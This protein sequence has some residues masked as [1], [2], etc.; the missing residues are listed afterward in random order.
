MNNQVDDI[1]QKKYAGLLIGSSTGLKGGWIILIAL[2]LGLA[3]P[4]VELATGICNSEFMDPL[5]SLKHVFGCYGLVAVQLFLFVVTKRRYH[6][7]LRG[8]I[9]ASIVF[10]ISWSFLYTCWFIPLMPISLIAIIVFGLGLF[11]LTPLV[12]FLAALGQS[13][14]IK[15]WCGLHPGLAKRQKVMWA[16][17]GLLPVLVTLSHPLV[18]SGVERWL[19]SESKEDKKKAAWLLKYGIGRFAH[20]KACFVNTSDIWH[21]ILN[22]KSPFKN[23]HTDIDYR[24]TLK[25]LYFNIYGVHPEKLA[26]LNWDRNS[27]DGA[28][29]TQHVG[30]NVSGLA[31]LSSRFELFPNE[32]QGIMYTEWTLEFENREMG[33]KEARALIRLP[34]GGVVSNVS[35]WI[36]GEE[37]QAAFGPVSRVV[38]AY[39]EIVTRKRDPLLVTMKGTQH[40]LAQCFP[41]L[42]K[43]P[44]KI[45]I[46]FTVPHSENRGVDLPAFQARNF[47]I[48]RGRKHMVK[49]VSGNMY[50]AKGL[51]A[52][53]RI[54]NNSV[55]IS[56]KRLKGADLMFF[57]LSESTT[58]RATHTHPIFTNLSDYPVNGSHTPVLLI[59]GTKSVLDAMEKMA[60]HKMQF[61]HIVVATPWGAEQWHKT[62]DLKKWL[63]SFTRFKKVNPA[64]A[65]NR[66]LQL[67]ESNGLPMLW[68][69]DD[70]TYADI[71]AHPDARPYYSG[72]ISTVI[73]TL[74]P[75]ANYHAY[76]EYAWIGR[77]L[78]PNHFSGDFKRDFI[79]VYHHA[80]NSVGPLPDMPL[81][82][83]ADRSK[84]VYSSVRQEERPPWVDHPYRLE[85]FQKVINGWRA[86][87]GI[88]SELLQET[89]HARLVTPV[90]GA[91]VLEN[92]VQYARNDLNPSHGEDFIPGTPEPGAYI[93]LAL[94]GICLLVIHRRNA[95][96][97]ERNV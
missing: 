51:G 5:P 7:A 35:L 79:S 76:V 15:A 63:R 37:R 46:G 54:R 58:I 48:P 82:T 74:A 19:V 47:T 71:Q 65:F 50:A 88:S 75:K 59:D 17:I 90:T 81:V 31:L 86:D 26:S 56:N 57:P 8:P 32:D 97:K 1:S 95:R 42:P 61:S 45:R 33:Q 92:A 34:E 20:G 83:T 93:L 77:H 30:E 70:F 80:S 2:F 28:Q 38:T 67:S 44:M 39:R 23:Q 85:L 84:D 55:S 72:N 49:I 22:K 53:Q 52:F 41:V 69:Q 6:S 18:M 12:Q 10:S 9:L 96:S 66:A 14:R 36:D 29:G 43:Q 21:P 87:G 78:Y 25:S 3:A 89:I 4:T 16:C 68:V 94:F 24:R 64:P 27:M 40:I 91:T 60:I 73:F 11:G 13:R 62:G